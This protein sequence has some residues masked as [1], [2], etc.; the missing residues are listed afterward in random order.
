MKK[1]VFFGEDG[2]VRDKWYQPYPIVVE[3]S[4]H[5]FDLLRWI[6]GLEPV[7][8]VSE[9]W[10]MPWNDKA[11]GKKNVGSI[12]KMNN[13]ARFSF[14]AISTRDEGESYPGHWTIEGTKGILKYKDQQIFLN[15]EKIWP[16]GDE[17][18]S[19]LSLENYNKEVL[20][21]SI[22]YFKGVLENV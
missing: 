7:T 2:G 3:I 14:R 4:V 18:Y 17:V 5:H 21:R 19:D 16:E 9:L 8:V 15:G 6:T 20:K 12:F 10:N 13:D 22:E 1:E 11:W